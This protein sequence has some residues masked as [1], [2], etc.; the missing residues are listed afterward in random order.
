MNKNDRYEFE[1]IPVKELMQLRVRE[2]LLICSAYDSFMLEEDGRVDEQIFEEYASLHLRYPPRFTQAF[3]EEAAM[4][5]LKTRS[6]DL[7]ISMVNVGGPD[8]ADLA[9]RIHTTYPS[10]PVVLLSPAGRTTGTTASVVH[11]GDSVHEFAWL[12]DDSILL[13][14]VKVIE[15]RRN[16]DRDVAEAGVQVIILVEDSVRFYSGYLPVIY[17]TLIQQGRN[18]MEEGLNEWEQTT[19]MRCRPKI[20]LAKTYEEATDLFDRYREHVLGVITD[21]SYPRGGEED[22][23]AGIELCRRIRDKDPDLPILVQSSNRDH[24]DAAREWNAEFLHKYAKDLYLQLQRYLRHHYGFGDILFRNPETGTVVAQASNLRELQ[25]II[26]DVPDESVVHHFRRND[27]SRWLRARALFPL[28]RVMWKYQPDL[29]DPERSKGGAYNIIAAYRRWQSRGKIARFDRSRYDVYTS[30]ARIGNGSLGGKGRGLAFVDHTLKNHDVRDR[31]PGVL[32]SI[33]RTVVLATDIFSRFMEAEE[34]AHLHTEEFSDDQI[35]ATVVAVDFDRELRADLRAVLTVIT[36]PIAVRSSS[37][38]EDSSYQPFAGVYNTFLLPNAADDAQRLSDLET[39]IKCVFASTYFRA[40]RDYLASVHSRATEEKMG[41]IIQEMTGTVHGDRCYPTISGVARSIN[42]Y[43]TE[44]ESSDDGVAYAAIGLGKSVVDGMPSLRFN[45]RHPDAALQLTDTEA[46]LRTTQKHFYALRMSM[47][48]FEAS[49]DEE[50]PLEVRDVRTAS[51]DP[52]FPLVVSTYDRHEHTLRDGWAPPGRPVVTMAGILKFDAFP[53][54][55]ILSD[56]LEISARE[57]GT[58][59][60]IEFAVDLNR[61]TGEPALFSFLQV[62]PIIPGAESNDVDLTGIDASQAL[63]YSASALGNGV[64]SDATHVLYVKPNAFDPANSR[65]IAEA[66]GTV[67]ER[68]AASG[69]QCVLIVPGRLGS[70]DPWLGIPVAWHHICQ[71]QVICEYELEGFVVD[72]SQGSHF[73]HNITA[74]RVGYLTVAKN[75]IDFPY[76]DASPAWFDERG[77]CA[78]SYSQGIETVIDGKNRV[79][80]VRYPAETDGTAREP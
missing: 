12:G 2:I 4:R 48:A 25:A 77:V 10:L 21:V 39:A 34:L 65:E 17:R 31:Y 61:P 56:L 50:T 40:S 55:Q 36:G 42:F 47:D 30:F 41:V 70:R 23:E 13:A 8:A 7:V 49:V 1:D 63:V 22:P 35:L 37:Q 57:L 15:D 20:L 60:E 9:H 38:L 79:A 73:F 46:A 6:F 72:P 58:P 74:L 80:L 29:T 44:H 64:L 62:R 51:E 24:R 5:F 71:A 27:V 16:V 43:P 54:A 19:R 28:A 52:S 66:I 11:R 32:V 78:V 67:N 69:E 75:A 59:V 26:R 68:M 18:L 14:I 3:S 76:L 33:P 53:L 45:P